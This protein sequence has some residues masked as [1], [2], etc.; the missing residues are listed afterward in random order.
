MP[1]PVPTPTEAQILTT[2]EIARVSYEDADTMI[3][4]D[5]VQAVSNAKWAATLLDVASWTTG[6]VGRDAGD[7]KRVDQIEFFESGAVNARLA[8]INA[9]RMRYGLSRLDSE[10]AQSQVTLASLN[11]IGDCYGRVR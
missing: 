5:S 10:A 3:S 2:S 6:G 4:A 8:I 9:V 7:V 11:W 1:T